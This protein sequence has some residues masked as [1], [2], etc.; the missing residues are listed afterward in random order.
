MSPRRMKTSPVWAMF[1]LIAGLSK[2]RK[3]FS[4]L[5]EKMKKR[6]QELLLEHEERNKLSAEPQNHKSEVAGAGLIYILINPSLPTN[7]LK[8][9]ATSRTP[10]ERAKELSEGT[11]IPT[12]YVVAYDESVSDWK[13]AEQAIHKRL[14]QKRV[15]NN[16]EFFSIPLKEAITVVSEVALE[17]RQVGEENH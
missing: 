12:E 4:A 2:V 7:M 17:F 3:D 16:R 8:I 10:E 13:L 9:G 11:G 6:K 15:R 5:N 1:E 14:E